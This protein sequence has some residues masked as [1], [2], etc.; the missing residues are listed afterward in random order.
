LSY[1][2]EYGNDPRH[3]FGFVYNLGAWASGL[4]TNVKNVSPFGDKLLRTGYCSFNRGVAS[5]VRK[6]VWC[7]INDAHEA[8]FIT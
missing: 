4:S 7:D 2:F 8:S 1:S 5:T 3:F 6:R